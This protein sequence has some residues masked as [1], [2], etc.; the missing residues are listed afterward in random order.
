MRITFF[1]GYDI[2]INGNIYN[3][4]GL[5][6]KTHKNKY[7]YM[8]AAISVNGKTKNFLVHRLIA[9]SF[10]PNPENKPYVNHIDGNKTNN[11]VSNLEWITPKDNAIHAIENKLYKTV[12]ILNTKESIEIISLYNKNKFDFEK[13]CDQYNITF[14]QLYNLLFD[15]KTKVHLKEYID[16]SKK[17]YNGD[18]L[19]FSDR[20]LRNDFIV[21]EYI[22]GIYGNY[23]YI[24]KKYGIGKSMLFNIV[25]NVEK[26]KASIILETLETFSELD[27][28]AI[29]F[30]ALKYKVSCTHVKNIISAKAKV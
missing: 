1:E 9:Q 18:V 24:C 16:F 22:P 5:V 25:K 23:E 10:I 30:V 2:D 6:L 12:N 14:S 13:I 4:D 28:N 19:S 15:N 8:N 7:G 27:I 3:K 20:E 26:N 11:D 21:S 29:C 17:E